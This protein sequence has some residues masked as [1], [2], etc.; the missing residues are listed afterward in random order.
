MFIMGIHLPGKIV[1]I[2]NQVQLAI[3]DVAEHCLHLCMTITWQTRHQRVKLSRCVVK[4]TIIGS[5]S[6]L[7]QAIIWTNAGVLLN[8]PLG[9]NFIE[10]LIGIQIF[11]L[12]K[13]HLKMSSA[14]WRPFCLGLNV[15]MYAA[16][17]IMVH[18]TDKVWWRI[19]LRWHIAS[20]IMPYITSQVLILGLHPANERRR[21]FVTTSLI[22][23]A[24]AQNQPCIPRAK[25]EQLETWLCHGW[26]L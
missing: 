25:S 9:T 4:L 12:K 15:L 19:M 8:G 16:D 18:P 23:C 5:D 6:D 11:S 14:K 20:S 7:S 17:E 1:F 3:W 24:Q 22:G 13:M 2:L 26:Y 10:I 21:Y